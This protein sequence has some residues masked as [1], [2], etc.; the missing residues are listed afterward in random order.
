MGGLQNLL[1]QNLKIRCIPSKSL[2]H[3]K[4]YAHIIEKVNE[5]LVLVGKS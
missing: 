2:V 5:L 1:K 3:N 4:K